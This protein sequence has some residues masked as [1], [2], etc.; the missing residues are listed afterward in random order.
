[1][2]G[3]RCFMVGHLLHARRSVFR[4]IVSDDGAGGRRSSWV[5]VGD[6]A[7]RISQPSAAERVLAMQAGAEASVP[8]YLAP[9]ADVRR[10]DE[11]RD[12]A[13]NVLRVLA[14]VV[15][16]RPVYLRAD[17]QFVQPKGT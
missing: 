1:M 15:P 10:G 5:H 13:G 14:T 6:V 4:E 11:L 9:T 3:R 7:C 2:V 8:V 16:S 17:C 12:E